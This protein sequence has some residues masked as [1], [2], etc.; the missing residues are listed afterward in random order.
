MTIEKIGLTGSKQRML[1]SSASIANQQ[2]EPNA[3]TAFAGANGDPRDWTEDSLRQAGI[4]AGYQGAQ[5]SQLKGKASENDK[6]FT[7][8]FTEMGFGILQNTEVNG[9]PTAHS[10]L[11]E[12]VDFFTAE[13][14]DELAG[15]EIKEGAKINLQNIAR[16]KLTQDT[17][18]S[19]YRSAQYTARDLFE[20]GVKSAPTAD[21]QAQRAMSLMSGKRDLLANMLCLAQ[22]DLTK[23][24]KLMDPALRDIVNGKDASVTK[25]ETRAKKIQSALDVALSG[26][27]KDWKT[28]IKNEA[29]E[30]K[31]LNDTRESLK[32]Y[33]D[34]QR[35]GF[36]LN[37]VP[38]D[39]ASRRAFITE[40]QSV[41]G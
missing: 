39:H 4:R 28:L 20:R 9:L 14:S 31:S 29:D 35:K 26:Q 37:K 41:I 19:A 12:E 33:R 1:T 36:Q 21:T 34:E 3:E 15:T 30:Q 18:N 16:R 38:K 2:T 13:Y 23:A 17:Y 10:I 22:A 32:A 11:K 40:M 24:Q 6:A 5:A 7:E 8:L 27:H 25:L